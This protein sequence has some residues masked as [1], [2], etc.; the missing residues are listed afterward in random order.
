MWI[1]T[2]FGGTRAALDV[3]TCADIALVLATEAQRLRGKAAAP[4]FPFFIFHFSFSIGDE[5]FIN[6][7]VAFDDK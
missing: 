3:C 5:H 2:V 6:H 4:D 1:S 7:R